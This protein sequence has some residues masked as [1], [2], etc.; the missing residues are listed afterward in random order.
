MRHRPAVEQVID[1]IY[2]AATDPQGWSHALHRLG[3]RFGG[4]PAI[5]WLQSLPDRPIFS[6]IARLDEE[7]QP[8]FFTRYAT[9]QTNPAIPHL[10]RA[11]Q[12]RP[13]DFVAAMGGRNVFHKTEIY[14][15][16]F[17][18]Q[19]IWSRSAAI[20][21]REGG[22]FAPLL[23]QGPVGCEPLTAA[24]NEELAFLLTHM[25]RALRVT[26][27][28]KRESIE[29]EAIAVVVERLGTGVALVDKSGKVMWMNPA[30]Q[31]IARNNNGL[32]VKTG[33]LT[34]SLPG[35]QRML[36]RLLAAAC[37]PARRGGGVIGVSR[38]S[39]D[40][41]YGVEVCPL[42]ARS[43]DFAIPGAALVFIN[44]PHRPSQAPVGA[45]AAIYDL[46]PAEARVAIAVA[47]QPTSHKVADS[48]K[49]SQNTVKTHLRHIFAKTG[50]SS[51]VEL[52]RL[53]T[54]M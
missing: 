48:L 27:R 16:L 54:L 8:V 29:R 40:A 41:R 37:D 20:I 15:D 45:L 24:E 33:R 7:L 31:E 6:A 10:L 47:S 30:A 36:E 4:S 12:A 3:D 28:L 42:S 50:T 39:G 14:S 43:S 51:R 25:A 21:F 23:V 53:L 2:D 18:P 32:S 52:V 44:D 34:A 1:S 49:L 26:A 38:P 9:P 19:R 17:V 35:E 22:T 13:F 5:I 11:A 46:T